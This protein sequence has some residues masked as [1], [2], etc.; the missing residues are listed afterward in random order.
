MGIFSGV[1]KAEAKGNYRYIRP[2]R[3][4][5]LIRACKIVTSPKDQTQLYV[6]E[7]EPVAILRADEDIDPSPLFSSASHAIK[8]NMYFAGTLKEMFMAILCLTPEEAADPKKGLT[9]EFL[10]NLTGEDQPLAGVIVELEVYNKKTKSGGEF[11]VVQY[12]R[13]SI[14]D[15]EDRITAEELKDAGVPK[16]VYESL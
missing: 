14:E 8:Q 11:T 12:L 6:N 9:E 13:S 5:A 16:E 3:Y 10:E 2:G 7:L 15:H 4:F 1:L